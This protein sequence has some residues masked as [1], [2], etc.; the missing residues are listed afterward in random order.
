VLIV[1]II[2]MFFNSLSGHAMYLKWKTEENLAC[3]VFRRKDYNLQ[4]DA[5]KKSLF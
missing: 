2:V 4:E 3:H 5:E 1:L